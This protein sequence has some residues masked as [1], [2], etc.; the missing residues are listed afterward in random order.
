M[1]P[2]RGL[3]RFVIAMMRCRGDIPTDPIELPLATAVTA[4]SYN[5]EPSA[6]C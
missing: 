2:S 5:G 6:V 1:L 4:A 3:G